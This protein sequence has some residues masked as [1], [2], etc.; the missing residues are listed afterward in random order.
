[1]TEPH[2][3]AD[4]TW[5]RRY[6]GTISPAFPP[7][8]SPTLREAMRNLLTVRLPLGALM[9]LQWPFKAISASLD[10]PIDA[11]VEK[12]DRILGPPTR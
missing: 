10:R 6:G 11:L 1:M 3:D 9:L 2:T 7:R 12:V 5:E 8:R 4:A